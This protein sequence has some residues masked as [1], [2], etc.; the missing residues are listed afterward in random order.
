MEDEQKDKTM[1]LRDLDNYRCNHDEF[2]ILELKQQEEP[3]E[4]D[5]IQ[6]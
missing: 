3:L 4:T 6:C 1:T 5:E 2:Q